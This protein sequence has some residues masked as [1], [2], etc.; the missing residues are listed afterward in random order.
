MWMKSKLLCFFFLVLCSPAVSWPG[1]AQAQT[2]QAF[3]EYEVKRAFVYNFLKF[4]VFPS[5]KTAETL[6]IC[7][8]DGKTVLQ[9]FAQMRG[10][11]VG[12]KEIAIIEVNS[13]NEID[14]C[15]VIFVSAS[16]GKKAGDIL[17]HAKGRGI[18]TIGE[19]LQFCNMGGMICF[20]AA[21]KT[22]RFGINL[23]DA[24]RESYNFSSQLLKLAQIVE[25]QS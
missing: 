9:F 20:I 23:K 11:K 1:G 17:E 6:D 4:T 2:N 5:D 16:I 14:R 24:K 25:R 15:D 18:L 19:D 21:E 13:N 3:E 8:A 10:Y 22:L 7:V 12:V